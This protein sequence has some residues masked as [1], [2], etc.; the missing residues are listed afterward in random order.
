[1]ARRKSNEEITE[2][3]KDPGF[4][5]QPGQV[6]KNSQFVSICTRKDF[7]AFLRFFCL[8]IK[9]TTVAK[10]SANLGT[11]RTIFKFTPGPHTLLFRRMEGQTANFTPRG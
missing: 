5:L 1:V 9:N 2:N 3:P 6:L 10:Y 8:K 4:L 7:G 11:L